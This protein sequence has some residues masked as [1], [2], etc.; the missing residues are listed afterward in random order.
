M[1]RDRSTLDVP[2]DLSWSPRR[3]R[4]PIARLLGPPAQHLAIEWG[5][6]PEPLLQQD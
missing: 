6:P 2:R 3:P 1:N 4:R 5:R